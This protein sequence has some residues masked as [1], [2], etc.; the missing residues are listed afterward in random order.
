MR[1]EH[2]VTLV[3]RRQSMSGAWADMLRTPGAA[4]T[5]HPQH[6]PSKS[7]R[8]GC[9][10]FRCSH[11]GTA[12]RVRHANPLWLIVQRLSVRA[13]ASHAAPPGQ[14]AIGWLQGKG[15]EMGHRLGL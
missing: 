9:S 4:A 1:A 5:P 11:A 3:S 14:D 15:G 6:R 7:G 13:C 12:S 2:P 8:L 10:S